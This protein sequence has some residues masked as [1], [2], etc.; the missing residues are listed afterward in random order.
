MQ[1]C[2]GYI[3]NNVN[4]YKDKFCLFPSKIYRRKRDICLDLPSDLTREQFLENPYHQNIYNFNEFNAPPINIYHYNRPIE[5]ICNKSLET[6]SFGCQIYLSESSIIEP[7]LQLNG[8]ALPM[9]LPGKVYPWSIYA[10]YLYLIP[11]ILHAK[12]FL[13]LQAPLCL[14]IPSNTPKNILEVLH[15]LNKVI[16]FKVLKEGEKVSIN[17][18]FLIEGALLIVEKQMHQSLVNLL[19]EHEL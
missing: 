3:K 5:F 14:I 15:Q 4:T 13:E 17:T 10:N 16:D 9:P 7:T 1:T 8:I 19:M 18:T 2:A 6:P 12:N 11:L